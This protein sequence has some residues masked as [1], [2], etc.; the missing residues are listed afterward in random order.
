MT[1]N[2]DQELKAKHLK[3]L[4]EAQDE[5]IEE[6]FEELNEYNLE[7]LSNTSLEGN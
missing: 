2:E 7:F 3:M 1:S 6:M 4:D 5:R